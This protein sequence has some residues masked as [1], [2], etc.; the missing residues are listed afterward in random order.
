ML[1]PFGGWADKGAAAVHRRRKSTEGATGAAAR[2]MEMAA[3]LGV[4]MVLAALASAA[5]PAAVQAED[6]VVAIAYLGLAGQ[7]KP[8]ASQLEPP[9]TDEGLQG[10]RLGLAD[11][12]TTGRVHRPDVPSR[13]G[14]R[15]G[16]RR[17]ARGGQAHARQPG[18]ACS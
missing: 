15:A 3:R 5:A 16:R 9:P 6:S 17:R 2:R 7:T 4:V 18:S 10:A 1:G 11:D 13:R 12:Q 14:G 8:P